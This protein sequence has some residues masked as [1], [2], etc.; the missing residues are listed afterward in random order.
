LLHA[1]RSLRARESIPVRGALTGFE[2]RTGHVRMQTR[3]GHRG[4]GARRLLRR[5]RTASRSS[6]RRLPRAASFPSARYGIERHGSGRFVAGS[7][8][9]FPD[10]TFVSRGG[11]LHAGAAIAGSRAHAVPALALRATGARFLAPSARRGFPVPGVRSRLAR[12]LCK[13]GGPRDLA[14]PV[15]AAAV[16]DMRRYSRRSR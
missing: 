13:Y 3:Q 8:I 2:A 14:R 9:P 7:S 16:A 10:P 4:L 15:K 12:L 6:P 11:A 5:S 1:G